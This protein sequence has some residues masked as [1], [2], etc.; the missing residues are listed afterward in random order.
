MRR[1]VIALIATLAVAGK[2]MGQERQGA[3]PQE[4][5]RPTQ[6]GAKVAPMTPRQVQLQNMVQHTEQLDLLQL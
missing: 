2:L 5:T 4:P 3:Q 6:Q 1:T